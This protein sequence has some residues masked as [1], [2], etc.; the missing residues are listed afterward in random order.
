M[1]FAGGRI[2]CVGA[3]NEW[4]G[5]DLAAD[6]RHFEDAVLLPGLINPHTHLELSCYRG[7][8]PSHSLWSWLGELVR[9]RRAPGTPKREAAG[10]RAGVGESLAAGVT[11]VG[12]ISRSGASASVLRDLPIRKV[13]FVELLGLANEPP[14]TIAELTKA[15]KV[16]RPDERLFPGVSPHAPYTVHPRNVRA[17]LQL[18]RDRGLPW[19]MHWLETAE[20]RAW[21]SGA[22]AAIPEPIRTLQQRHDLSLRTSSPADYLRDVLADAPAGLLAHGNYVQPAEHALLAQRGDTLAYC[23]RTHRY[24]SHPP[25]P[26]RALLDAGV[27]VALATDS[28]ASS[29]SLSVLDEARFVYREQPDQATPIELLRM[30]TLDAATALGQGQHLGS[31]T[32]GKWADFAVFPLPSGVDDPLRALLE[33]NDGPTRVYVGGECVYETGRSG[34]F[35]GSRDGSGFLDT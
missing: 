13:C 2:A 8:I 11:C 24:F 21:L 26:L 34:G 23:P 15:L 12:D 7:A 14:R 16:M 10:I 29:P 18:A 9:L 31:L 33:T 17:A 19:C 6:H 1:Q 4:T 30:I 32:P 22:S 25:Y 35:R 28:L 27:C 5:S 20:E 3:L